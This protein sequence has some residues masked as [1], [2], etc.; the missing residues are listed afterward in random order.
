[1]QLISRWLFIAIAALL[2]LDFLVPGEQFEEK[3]TEV[4]R[5]QQRNYKTPGNSHY[6]YHVRTP[7]NFF[8]VSKPIAAA[9]S[10]GQPIQYRMSYLFNEIN[11][12][13]LQND[14]RFT[15]HSMQW[16]AGL[17][18]P[19]IAIVLLLFGINR[20]KK[21]GTLMFVIQGLVAADLVYHLY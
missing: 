3:V 13:R 1:M 21:Y 17:V 16:F 2:V 8:L 14:E 15:R 4:V 7:Q 6:T 20:P 10:I 12:Y 19:L 9:I 5:K 11:G 18:L